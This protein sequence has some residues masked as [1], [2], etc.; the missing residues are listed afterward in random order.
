MSP[1][2]SWLMHKLQEASSCLWALL[3]ITQSMLAKKQVRSVR[4]DLFIARFW[5][6]RYSTRAYTMWSLVFCTHA[7]K[8]CR[9]SSGIAPLM[10]NLYARWRWRVNVTSRRFHPLMKKPGTQWTGGWVGPT[11]G[12]AVSEKKA[13]SRPHI[14]ESMYVAVCMFVCKVNPVITTSI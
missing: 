3:G 8:A 2:I 13:V 9:W 5:T 11:A 12:L 7:L 4:G 10:L 1:V 14:N 6:F